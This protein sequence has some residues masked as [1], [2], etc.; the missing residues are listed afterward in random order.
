MF[1][2]SGGLSLGNL[3]G[4]SQ[5]SLELEQ[6][7]NLNKENGSINY[8][9]KPDDNE[10]EDAN[11]YKTNFDKFGQT[12]NINRNTHYT[13]HLVENTTDNFYK[14][15]SQSRYP[16]T[17][18]TKYWSIDKGGLSKAEIDEKVNK[19]RE[20]LKQGLYD[21]KIKQNL[22]E[23][24]L[25]D[26]MLGEEDEEKIKNLKKKLEVLKKE[27]YDKIMKIER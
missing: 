4:T 12:G 19:L 20:D 27:N 11:F 15:Q 26:A 5:F 8:D 1:N 14:N 7:S 2:L 24:A 22:E 25:E 6:T 17:G 10:E 16:T 21:L 3:G 23:K 13:T 18:K 9:L